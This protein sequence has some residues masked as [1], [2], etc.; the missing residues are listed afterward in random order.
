MKDILDE[1][2]ANKRMEVARQKEAVSL[3]QLIDLCDLSFLPSV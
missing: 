1:I 2:V 3:K